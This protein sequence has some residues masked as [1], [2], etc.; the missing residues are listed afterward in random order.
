MPDFRRIFGN[1]GKRHE[2]SHFLIHKTVALFG[3]E[4]LM[5][6]NPRYA[7]MKMQFRVHDFSIDESVGAA[8]QGIS[9][10]HRESNHHYVYCLPYKRF[11]QQLSRAIDVTPNWEDFYQWAGALL[12]EMPHEWL[13]GVY[14]V[15]ADNWKR[16]KGFK[17]QH[18]PQLNETALESAR[19]YFNQP[20][21]KQPAIGK[22]K[23][24]NGKPTLPEIPH[25]IEI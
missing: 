9:E 7:S 18:F 3:P 4:N 23:K 6:I 11:R 25:L 2:G 22:R 12:E 15:R 13:V 20:K 10:R 1:L 21:E 16:N 17:P 24:G 8:V 5:K 14:D 19:K